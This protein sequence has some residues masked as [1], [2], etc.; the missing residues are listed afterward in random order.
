MTAAA[1][2]A[3]AANSLLTRAAL[4]GTAIDPVSFTALRIASGALVLFALI[5]WRGESAPERPRIRGSWVSAFALFGYALLFSLA[6]R[7]LS[8]ATGALLL[9]GAVQVTMLSVALARGESLRMIQWIGLMAA[10]GGI[11]LLLWPGLAAPPPLDA[12][13]MLV[14]GVAWGIYT[15]RARGGDPTAV[16]AWNFLRASVPALALL[17]VFAVAARWDPLGVTYAVLSGALASGL[18]YAIWYAALP[19][20]GTHTAAVS[21]LAVPVITALGGV[22]LLA[23]PLSPRLLGSGALVLVGIGLVV[24]GNRPGPTGG[25]AR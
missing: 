5:V 18:G 12:A 2:F 1:L 22:L 10:L 24:T 17:G 9:F 6:Y 14:A 23:E 19:R 3:F 21:Q 7:G 25:R 16:T 11:V 8:A 15:L 13:C 20:I 4:G